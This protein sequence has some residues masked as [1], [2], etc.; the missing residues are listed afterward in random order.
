MKPRII[1]MLR[2]PEPGTVKTRLIPALGERRACELYRSLVRHTLDEVR[3]FAAWDDMA[4]EARVA[5]APDAT[6]ASQ[7]L[8]ASLLC[9]EQG[10]GDLGQRMERAVR[11]AFDEGAPA[12][13]VIGAD[14][15]QLAAQHMRS[16]FGGLQSQDVVLGPAADGGY[17]LI[18][19]RKFLPELFRGIQWSSEAV[20]EQT[21]SAARAAGIRCELLETLGDLDRPYDLH[22]WA[23]SSAGQ[24]EGK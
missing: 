9:R 17:Y 23:R 5:D 6:A 24:E 14:C 3:Q 1:I 16:A 20:L 10:E 12:V 15:P 22:L 18:G 4:V 21:L 2:Y 19:L 8:G 13:V 7:W 11:D